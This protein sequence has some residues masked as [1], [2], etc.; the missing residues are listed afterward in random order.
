MHTFL[1]KQRECNWYHVHIIIEIRD[2]F[3]SFF[4]VFLCV[5][6]SFIIKAFIPNND[7]HKSTRNKSNEVVPYICNGWELNY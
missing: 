3:S 6:S 7:F 5:V 2:Y 4:S 1:I